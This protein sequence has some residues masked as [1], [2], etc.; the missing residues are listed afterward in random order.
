MADEV[1]NWDVSYMRADMYVYIYIR[2]HI[3]I[4]IVNKYLTA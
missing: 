1:S 2:L 3:L 4:H